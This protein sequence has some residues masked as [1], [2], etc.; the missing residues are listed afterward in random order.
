MNTTATTWPGPNAIQAGIERPTAMRL[1][2]TEYQRVTDAVDALQAEDWTRPTDCTA[3]D[4]RQLVAHIAGQANLFSTPLE[5]ARQTRAAK[6][7]QQPGQ[8][9]VD[10]LTALQ[11]E[12]RQHLG[13]EQLRAELHRVGP[14]GARGRRRI[15]GFLRRRRSLGNRG[16]QRCTGG[17]VTRLRHRCDPHS[18]R[19]DAPAGPR[20]GNGSRP[21]AH[22]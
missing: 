8:A 16:R 13:P 10:A 15:P 2:D 17:M 7:R 4:V 19:V 12:D 18:R 6:A 21:C 1:A 22:R 14:R 3:W 5:V 9:L 11:V 20:S